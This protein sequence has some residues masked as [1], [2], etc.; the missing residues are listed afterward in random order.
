MSSTQSAAMFLAAVTMLL[1]TAVQVE[2]QNGN[3]EESAAA[4]LFAEDFERCGDKLPAGWWVEGG[5]KVWI[6]DGRLHIRANA[7]GN[8]ARDRSNV[9]N[10]VCTVWNETVFTRDMQIDFDAHIVASVGG[11]NNI[12]FFFFYSHPAGTPLSETR[13]TRADG[14]YKRYHKLNGYIVTFLQGQ[15]RIRKYH[16]DGAA[17]ARFRMRR[18]PGFNLID[19]GFDY[20]CRTGRT[21]HIT[22]TKR[23][24]LVSYAVDGKTYAQAEDPEPLTRGIIG[25]RTFRTELWWDNFRVTALD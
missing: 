13:D 11:V 5:K 2:G 25:L 24:S 19:E 17:K 8:I 4:L 22:V 21:Y 23:G 14:D 18:C 1:A 7:E 20:H 6:E 3:K 10:Y 12:N 16:P 15:E 9:S